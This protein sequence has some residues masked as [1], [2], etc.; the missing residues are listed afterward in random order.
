[1]KTV[2]ISYRAHF[3]VS[4]FI[5]HAVYYSYLGDVCEKKIISRGILLCQK[6]RDDILYISALAH[7]LQFEHYS[8]SGCEFDDSVNI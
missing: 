2:V 6:L 4:D 5:D 7:Q 3:V 1:M 8:T